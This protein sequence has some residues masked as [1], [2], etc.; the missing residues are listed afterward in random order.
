MAVE[1]HG[2]ENDHA[3]RT[4]TF[5][6]AAA[7]A[8][9][10]WQMGIAL[11]QSAVR[12]QQDYFKI[13]AHVVQLLCE[14][15]QWVRGDLTDFQRLFIDDYLHRET[16]RFMAASLL[17]GQ[18]KMPKDDLAKW[19]DPHAEVRSFVSAGGELPRYEPTRAE[20]A[21]MLEIVLDLIAA[22]LED[23]V[24]RATD[25]ARHLDDDQ[26][27]KVRAHLAA[28][29]RWLDELEAIIADAQP[30]R[31]EAGRPPTGVTV[32]RREGL[33]PEA[34][35]VEVVNVVFDLGIETGAAE[36]DMEDLVAALAHTVQGTRV[37]ALVETYQ[38]EWAEVVRVDPM[39]LTGEELYG[40]SLQEARRFLRFA[41]DLVDQ[42][43]LPPSLREVPERVRSL[44][45]AGPADGTES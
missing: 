26:N 27:R 13:R 33:P 38:L 37:R 30:N 1:V 2:G 40:L 18:G 24:A 5:A 9:A 19:M 4:E 15:N 41:A 17:V 39:A 31:S 44:A 12:Q 21:R 16:I 11:G 32:R 28:A 7:V 14:T 22:D 36:F 35:A 42:D 10:L 23:A 29:R 6:R 43:D 45:D 34:G 3:D 20:R 25:S 8:A